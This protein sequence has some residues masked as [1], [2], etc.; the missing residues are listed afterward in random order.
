MVTCDYESI[1]SNIRQIIRD[2]GMKQNVVA[3]RAG[4]SSQE[5]SN[6]LND[7]RKLLR[8]EHLPEIA[9]ALN[10]DVNEL[11]YPTSKGKE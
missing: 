8:V 7:N 5:L 11:F 4:F 6:I 10:V 1:I 9:H 3:E 2:K